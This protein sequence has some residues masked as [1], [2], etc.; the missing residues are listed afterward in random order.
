MYIIIDDLDTDTQVLLL[1][2]LDTSSWVE[3]SIKHIKPVQSVI[4]LLLT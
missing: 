1:R 4:T 2:P 3:H